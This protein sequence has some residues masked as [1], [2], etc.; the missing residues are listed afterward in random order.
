MVEEEKTFKQMIEEKIDEILTDKVFADED[1]END[2][3]LN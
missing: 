1:E 2:E 3:D